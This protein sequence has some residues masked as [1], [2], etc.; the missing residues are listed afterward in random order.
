MA[1]KPHARILILR[2]MAHTRVWE[3]GMSRCYFE[4]SQLSGMILSWE[5]NIMNLTVDQCSLALGVYTAKYF[6]PSRYG[7]LGFSGQVSE[8]SISLLKLESINGTSSPC[9]MNGSKL[10]FS[11]S[12]NQK[13][14]DDNNSSRMLSIDNTLIGLK[15]TELKQRLGCAPITNYRWPLAFSLDTASV[16]DLLGKIGVSL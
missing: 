13:L 15:I 3:K 6:Q 8:T 10:C 16:A 2:T 14:W 9:Y 12:F 5:P 11:Y 1:E 4:P 7:R